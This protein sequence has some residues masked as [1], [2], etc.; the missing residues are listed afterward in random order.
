MSQ[1]A[2]LST[3]RT[4][5]N[6]SASEYTDSQMGSWL[7]DALAQHNRT[8]TWTT[9]PS[10]EE[11]PVRLLAW[12]QV[13]RARAS[14]ASMYFSVSGE[15]GSVNKAE[16]LQNNLQMIE[17]LRRDYLDICGRLGLSGA[18]EV[19]V[20]D[21]QAVNPV[22]HGMVP[23]PVHQA[24]GTLTL[25]AENYAD[26][27]IEL[28]WTEAT[29]RSTFVRYRLFMGT[30]AGLQDMSTL[31]SDT[32]QTYQGVDNDKVTWIGDFTSIEQTRVRITG[33][34]AGVTYY[35]VVVLEDI[36][37]RISVSNEVAT[38]EASETPATVQYLTFVLAGTL[39]INTDYVSGVAFGRAITI[40]SISVSVTTAPS[41]GA[42]VVRVYKAAGGAGAY[43]EASV[44]SGANAGSNTGTFEIGA[45]E[46]L[47]VRTGTVNGAV[48]A[49]V[50][51]GYTLE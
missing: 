27:T 16:I 1:A 40:T 39:T 23:V 13:C 50:L 6:V 28:Y 33:L 45:A 4:D 41:G 10:T 26:T 7:D 17:Q 12:I 11:E 48:Q 30:V 34:T 36:N 25:F 21:L 32:P 2:L 35:F 15:E 42:C 29:P 37:S 22:I 19:R 5:A 24:P 47:Y 46:A 31:T 3:L 8:Y 38:T 9:L 43:L 20:S 49:T 18:P 51:L 14:K 44:A